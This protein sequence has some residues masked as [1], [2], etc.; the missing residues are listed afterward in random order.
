MLLTNYKE[1]NGIYKQQ[2]M[3]TLKTCIFVNF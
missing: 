3:L 1:N 2:I